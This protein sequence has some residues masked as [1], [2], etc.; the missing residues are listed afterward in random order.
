MPNSDGWR[1]SS[2]PSLSDSSLGA[3]H[4][5][6]TLLGN[7]EGADIYADTSDHTGTWRRITTLAATVIDSYTASDIG[8]GTQVTADLTL[9]AGVTIF[10]NF[11]Q[12]KLTSGAIIA[13]R[14]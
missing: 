5:L 14:G 9:A 6:N 3:L 11:S 8:A 1:T 7:A 4:K 2:K 12:I 13:Y 10:G